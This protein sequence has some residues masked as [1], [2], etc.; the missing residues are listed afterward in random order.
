MIIDTVILKEVPG[1]S[2]TPQ[3]KACISPRAIN[4]EHMKLY[5]GCLHTR[6]SP[7]SVL[8]GRL[9]LFAATSVA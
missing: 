6:R 8:R 7:S 9:S 3:G 5:F 4:F 2:T 1:T